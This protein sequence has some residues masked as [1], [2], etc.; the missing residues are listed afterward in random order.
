MKDGHFDLQHLAKTG[1]EDPDDVSL[2]EGNGLFPP[3]VEYNTYV[4]EVVAFLEEVSLTAVI[5]PKMFL[6]CFI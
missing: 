4:R 3:D 2:L 6:I 5:K 1:A